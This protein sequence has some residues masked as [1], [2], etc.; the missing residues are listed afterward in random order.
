MDIKF[1]ILVPVYN[2][3]AYLPECVDSILAQTYTNFEVILVDDGSP[4]RC[5]EM[6][7]EY[8]VQDSR[9][10]VI[11]KQN[12]GL[13]SARKAGVAAAKGE[14]ICFVDSDDFIA[15]D[16]L[17]TYYDILKCKKVDIICAGYT[18]YCAG[19]TTKMPQNAKPG[20]YSKEQLK[21]EIYPRM[22]SVKPHAASLILPSVSTKCFRK[23]IVE[24]VYS[25]VPNEIA[26]GED[27]AVSYP[28]LL[29]SDAIYVTDYCGY[30]YR[31]N[32]DSMTHA[33]RKNLYVN[34]KLLLSHLYN[35][36][37][38]FQWDGKQQ[39]QEFTVTTLFYIKDNELIY[40][41]DS[42]YTVKKRK[43]L[44][45]LD[46]PTFKTAIDSVQ[47]ENKMQRLYLLCLKHHFILPLYLW[48][49]VKGFI[50]GK[51]R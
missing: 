19:Q 9:V 42:K 1:S 50:A 30:M 8:A 27:V 39:I 49:R 29:S 4:D 22:M 31:Q 43:L 48:S 12:G 44:Q 10:R 18:S 5:G 25:S 21:K 2:V 40:N 17:E 14:F 38:T 7:D 13:I 34:M 16:M 23:Q 24:N 36:A 6:C 45:Y 41:Q 3:E 46:D 28:A 51:Q 11:H 15:N 20:Y 35:V 47:F 33:H 37:E 26:I 32:P